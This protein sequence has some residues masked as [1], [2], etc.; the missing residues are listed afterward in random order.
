M[1]LSKFFKNSSSFQPQTLVDTTTRKNSGWQNV[2][3]LKS[4]SEPFSPEQQIKEKIERA[5]GPALSEPLAHSPAEDNDLSENLVH[6]TPLTTDSSEDSDV[7]NEEEKTVVPP[8]VPDGYVSEEEVLL[9][10]QSA[11]QRGQQ[12]GFNEGCRQTLAKQENDFDTASRAM[13]RIC[14]QLETCR[15]TLINNSSKEFQ[16]FA[17]A[18][19]EQIIRYSVKHHDQ[20]ILA[21]IEEALQRSI[22]SSEFYIYINPEDYDIIERKAEEIIAGVNG[23]ENII[24]KKDPK[25]EQGGARIESENCTIDATV[26]S[27]FEIIRKE[28]EQKLL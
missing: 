4:P 19:A 2:T 7:Q 11:Y 23:L 13:S 25:I 24:L 16:E 20:T 10:E 8:L 22:K 27:Q 6:N 5:K 28:V 14:T 3:S 1:S 17:L 15:D 12:E 9:R 26:A 21:T 18:I